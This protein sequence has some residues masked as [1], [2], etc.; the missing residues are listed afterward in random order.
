[1]PRPYILRITA[2]RPI[3]KKH[4]NPLNIWILINVLLD[5]KR[6]FFMVVGDFG[7]STSLNDRWLSGAEATEKIRPASK[8]DSNQNS[9][10]ERIIVFF[11]DGTFRSYT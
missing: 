9:D 7:V 6:D 1:M 3:G 2:E 5:F 4:D 11:T 8:P 10:I